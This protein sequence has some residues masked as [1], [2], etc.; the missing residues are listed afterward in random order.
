MFRSILLLCATI[1]S[2]LGGSAANAATVNGKQM[3]MMKSGDVIVQQDKN[4]WSA[5]KILAVDAWPDGTS[6][7]HCL[8]YKPVQTKPTVK[9]LESAEVL[10]WHAPIDAASFNNGWEKIGNVA[11][12]KTEL[13]GLVEYLRLT[14]FPRYLKF[15]GQDGNELV[16]KSNAHYERANTLAN[17]GKKSEAI[18]EYTHAIEI[19]PL[20]Y[21]AVDNRAFTHM[22]LGKFREALADFEESLRINPN[23][24]AAFFSKGECLMK[25]GDLKSAEAIFREGQ[26][27]FPEQRDLFKKFLDQ[28][29]ALLKKP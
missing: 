28:V 24:M 23:G 19:F 8:T 3:L 6:A 4:G 17:Q 2:T 12:T 16:R 18:V 9:S 11:A 27:R 13:I 10:V 14:D 7:A 21:E 5:I 25:L 1:L 15:T 26:G 29:K 20:F 22:E